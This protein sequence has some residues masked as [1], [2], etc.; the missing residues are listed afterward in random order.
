MRIGGYRKAILRS[1][2]LSTI[3][4]ICSKILSQWRRI[5]G[6]TKRSRIAANLLL[7]DRR[8]TCS[9]EGSRLRRERYRLPRSHLASRYSSSLLHARRPRRRSLSCPA[10]RLYGRCTGWSSWRLRSRDVDERFGLGKRSCCGVCRRAWLRRREIVLVISALAESTASWTDI[11]RSHLRVRLRV[12]QR[13]LFR[14]DIEAAFCGSYFRLRLRG[15]TCSER[16]LHR[17][18]GILR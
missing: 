15:C 13:D 1:I 9:Q 4:P 12:E 17:T 11:G 3:V 2:A 16:L 8:S 14:L 18:C 6:R 10:S 7:P 5:I